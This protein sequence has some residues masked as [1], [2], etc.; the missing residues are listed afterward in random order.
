MTKRREFIRKSLVG[1]AG[2]AIGG[3]GLNARTYASVKG[4]NDRVNI[5]VVGIRGQGGGINR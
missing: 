5:A 1:S 2:I 4:A 3:I